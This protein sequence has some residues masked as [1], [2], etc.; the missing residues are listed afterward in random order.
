[1]KMY[2]EVYSKNIRKVFNPKVVVFKFLL[3]IG[4]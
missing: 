4:Y 2:V 3:T 1:M